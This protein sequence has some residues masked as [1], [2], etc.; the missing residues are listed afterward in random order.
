VRRPGSRQFAKLVSSPD[1]LRPA[2]SAPFARDNSS[3]RD[4]GGPTGRLL[5]RRLV[6]S[7][8]GTARMLASP[9]PPLGRVQDAV[10]VRIHP[11]ELRTRSPRRALLGALDVLLSSEAAGARRRRARRGGAWLGGLVTCLGEGG[12]RQQ[13]QGEKSDDGLRTHIVRSPVD[14]MDLVHHKAC[15]RKPGAPVLQ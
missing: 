7:R 13:R 9:S 2:L 1:S 6:R 10:V 5:R 3:Y 14:I 15:R 8:S 4:S 12:R 11:V